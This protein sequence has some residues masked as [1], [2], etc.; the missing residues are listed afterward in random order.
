M[1]THDMKAV[2]MH[3]F[4]KVHSLGRVVVFNAASHHI[5][6]IQY[7]TQR[8]RRGHFVHMM[9]EVLEGSFH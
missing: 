2:G 6:L 7:Q 1:L 8:R 4:A 9:P 3:L 5:V